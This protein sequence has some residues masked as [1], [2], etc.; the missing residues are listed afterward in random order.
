MKT[1]SKTIPLSQKDGRSRPSLLLKRCT[2]SSH[3]IHQYHHS[4]F[5]T[6]IALPS[7]SSSYCIRHP[8]HTTFVTLFIPPSFYQNFPTTYQSA[9]YKIS[10]F[11]QLSQLSRFSRFSRFSTISTISTKIHPSQMFHPSSKSFSATALEFL[12]S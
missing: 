9:N 6:A 1:L 12:I 7:F 8:Y 10:H 3:R 5:V 11:S 4:A 2:P